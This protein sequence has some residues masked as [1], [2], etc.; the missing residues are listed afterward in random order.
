MYEFG[1]TGNDAVNPVN[2][3]GEFIVEGT[4]TFGFGAVIENK[5]V[6]EI[7]LTPQ[8]IVA[9]TGGDSISGSCFPAVRY[10]ATGVDS[11]TLK[12]LSFEYDGKS[13]VVEPAGSYWTFTGLPVSYTLEDAETAAD[14]DDIAGIYAI[15][16]DASKLKVMNEDG[17]VVGRYDVSVVTENGD[18]A[19]V[20]VRNV[21]NPDEVAD[22]TRAVVNSKEEV[23]TSDGIGAALIPEE[24]QFYTNGSN[25]NLGLIGG[26]NGEEPQVSLLFDDLL[27]G[28]EDATA[29]EL[30]IERANSD[31]GLKLEL[32]SENTEFKYLDLVKED[33]GNAWVSCDKPVTVYWPIPEGVE[34]KEGSFKVYH[35]M[36][37]HREYR[38]ELEQQI[39][40][41][42]IKPVDC[43]IEGDN[44]TFTLDAAPEGGCLSPFA[45]AWEPVDP[46][47]PEDPTN[48]ITVTKA[49]ENGR[50]FGGEFQFVLELEA[51][52][53]GE[54]LRH[55]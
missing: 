11:E 48:E 43:T 41:C 27:A 31:E 2:N 8:D 40:S 6:V 1:A 51:G 46:S 19:T 30:L 14:D 37:L 13:V 35:F 55:S 29:E 33:D 39:E 34:A 25:K 17:D 12:T 50:L 21:S 36:G 26:E 38:G 9:Y 16:I 45:L 3:L 5:H 20:I 42:T 18:P 10:A 4:E 23:D 54:F 32:T 47:D 22:V 44:V 24:A 7:A 53:E 15:G 52:P 28:T 49:L